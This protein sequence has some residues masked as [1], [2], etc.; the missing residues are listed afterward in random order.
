MVIISADGSVR[1]LSAPAAPATGST[2][3]S[4]PGL[5]AQQPQ[6]YLRFYTSQP[7]IRT[8]V[9]FLAR[10][11]AQL[12]I[13]VFRRLDDDD[14][15][16]LVDH[17][18]AVSLDAPN[19]GYTRY[20]MIED[21]V[22]DMGIYFNAYWAKLRATLP[23]RLGLVRLPPYEMTVS[24]GLLPTA[25]EWTSSI[26]GAT[27]TFAPQDI[28]H[29]RGYGG[30]DAPCMG[31]SP[32][33]TLRGILLEER[34]ATSY[35]AGYWANAARIEGVLLRQKDTPAGKWSNDQ[36]LEYARQWKANYTGR[37]AGGTPI[38]PVGM[39]WKPNAFSAR[40]S[41]Y[42]QGGKLRREICAASYHIPLP[43]VGILEHATFSNIKEQHKQLFT[44]CLGPWLQLFQGEF[45]RQILPEFRDTDRVYSEFN[46]AEKLKG[47][48]EEQAA[49][50]QTLIGSP[51]MTVNEGRGRLNLP[52][53]D[54]PACDQVMRPLNMTTTQGRDLANAETVP[55]AAIATVRAHWDRQAARLAKVPTAD[56]AQVFDQPRYDREL[57]TDLIPI[58]RALGHDAAVAARLSMTV[59]HQLNTHVK[60][61]LVA[62]H[63][64]FNGSRHD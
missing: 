4:P 20:R 53:Q 10:N 57:T 18:L 39:E 1:A 49:A 47:D 33:E 5:T 17:P 31:I 6:S 52:R 25:Y 8:C 41:E 15:V 62:G 61:L 7:N 45:H 59:A 42:V 13:H 35:R 51:V 21:L 44:D 40:D 36:V 32:L 2:P 3:S 14:R 22:T 19:P 23:D 37:G 46:I 48:F 34:E 54:D 11:I 12:G 9:E 28:V 55:Q 27:I 56:R 16:R 38:L 64:V 43:L 60:A 63:P 50:Y 30:L 58:Y 24:G 26:T 29:F